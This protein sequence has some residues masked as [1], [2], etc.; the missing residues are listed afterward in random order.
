ML[1]RLLW[2][3]VCGA[4]LLGGARFGT[5]TAREAAPSAYECSGSEVVLFNNT[6]AFPVVGG[7]TPPSFGTNGKAYCLTYLEHYHW[8]DGRG[9]SPGTI[10]LRRTAGSGIASF[11]VQALASAGQ[12]GAR[13][14]N[15][16][17]YVPRVSPVVLNGTYTCTDSGA[18][19]WSSNARS[20]GRGFCI[21]R[22][23]PAV[24]RAGGTTTSTTTTTT[25]TEEPG[26]RYDLAVT[27]TP[28]RSTATSAGGLLE[29][30]T[31]IQVR[32]REGDESEATTMSLRVTATSPRLRSRLKV[33]GAGTT[34]SPD[35]CFVPQLAPGKDARYVIGVAPAADA[36]P[37]E[38]TI[39][40]VV[41]C[42]K[43]EERNCDNNVFP[44]RA[45]S[46]PIVLTVPAAPAVTPGVPAGMT[47]E[48]Y[49]A[50]LAAAKERLSEL[51]RN[52]KWWKNTAAELAAL[53]G[54]GS[55]PAP[56]LAPGAAVA[57]Y[58]GVRLD[59]LG[60]AIDEEL[61]VVDDAIAS[62]RS[63]NAF[64]AVPPVRPGGEL[65][66]AV[67]TAIT[68]WDVAA[69]DVV[70]STDRLVAAVQASVSAYARGDVPTA[71]RAEA[72]AGRAA[73]AS[74]TAFERLLDTGVAA[75]ALPNALT[76]AEVAAARLEVRREGLPTAVTSILRSLRVSEADRERLRA[77]AGA[78]S[79]RA[80][81]PD[82]LATPFIRTAERNAAAG[83]RR[84]ATA[85]ASR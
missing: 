58:L 44:R 17:A 56:V 8:N 73:A 40:L 3:L 71:R 9:A 81:F 50:E 31:R 24:Q 34:C 22:G 78:A 13:N 70:S 38:L 36:P 69:L 85:V 14:V 4:L 54:L 10:G 26:R 61:E 53:V 42:A 74:A 77:R 29:F 45:A 80:G 5:A 51:L 59:R 66:P 28:I 64:R 33:V 18:A 49:R 2:T 35:S 65:T 63:P 43:T 23:I 48:Q 39:R 46:R 16:Y 83:L 67:A 6:N 72:A 11:S 25:T 62:T 7:G 12:G 47:K 20:G 60:D 75:A 32:N 84:Y 1:R 57:G 76:R 52:T 19:S 15:W 55:V 37:G 27:A 68:R 82:L 21:V 79:P 41:R 30:A